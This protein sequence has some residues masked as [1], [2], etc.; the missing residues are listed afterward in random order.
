ML[1]LLEDEDYLF[2]EAVVMGKYL[3]NDGDEGIAT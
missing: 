1:G 3:K 2:G